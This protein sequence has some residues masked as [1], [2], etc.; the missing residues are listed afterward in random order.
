MA[1]LVEDLDLGTKVAA[2][3]APLEEALVYATLI[4]NVASSHSAQ[5]TDSETEVLAFLAS[6]ATAERKTS[7]LRVLGRRL[8]SM[9]LA[10]ALLT[11]IESINSLESDLPTMFDAPPASSVPDIYARLRELQTQLA[12]GMAPAEASKRLA[13]A[14]PPVADLVTELVANSAP[15]RQWVQDTWAFYDALTSPVIDP[16]LGH[17]IDGSRVVARAIDDIVLEVSSD[18]LPFKIDAEAKLERARA[19]LLALGNGI[20][21]A[22]MGVDAVR[23]VCVS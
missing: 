21:S 20:R 22:L 9:Q 2:L 19:D 7:S 8:Q 10:D 14:V 4:S 6:Y 13:S 17:S 16:S 23:W 5:A 18:V 3:E 15:H 1:R 11:I 12:M